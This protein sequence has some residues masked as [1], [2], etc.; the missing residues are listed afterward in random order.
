MK[1]IP[2]RFDVRVRE[3]FQD[4][5]GVTPKDVEAYL[6]GLDPESEENI[7][8]VSIDNEEDAVDNDSKDAQP[9]FSGE[10]LDPINDHTDK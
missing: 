1:L 4:S 2:N 6:E 9:L 8:C 5:L 10:S 7:V 3:R